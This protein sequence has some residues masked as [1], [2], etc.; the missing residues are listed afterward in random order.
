MRPR[1][2]ATTLRPPGENEFY[3]RLTRFHSAL[4]VP[5]SEAE[6]TDNYR[7]FSKRRTH[8]QSQKTHCLRLNYTNNGLS[9]VLQ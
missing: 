5:G 1:V 9:F 2:S 8:L 6:N 7:D 3:G 4:H